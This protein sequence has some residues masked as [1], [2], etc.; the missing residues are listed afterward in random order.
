MQVHTVVDSTL[1]DNTIAGATGRLVLVVVGEGDDWMA[2]RGY[3]TSMGWDVERVDLSVMADG[4]AVD[5]LLPP[6]E[7]LDAAVVV[8]S[9]AE[10]RPALGGERHLAQVAR[11]VGMLQGHL[12]PSRVLVLAE[13]D[14]AGEVAGAGVG[15][16]VYLSGQVETQFPRLR[17]MLGEAGQR[18]SSG[19]PFGTT[20]LG[21]AIASLAPELWLVLGPL[22]VLGAFLAVLGLGLLNWRAT[23]SPSAP[24]PASPEPGISTT[25]AA[26]TD[27][28]REQEGTGPD[29]LQLLPVSCTIDTRLGT[30]LAP[31]ID[32]AGAGIVTVDGFSGPWHNELSTVALDSAVVGA[33]ILEPVGG[34]SAP[35]RVQ[36]R[37]GAETSLGSSAGAGVG[38]V[39]LV[40][41]ADGQRAIFSGPSA[42]QQAVLTFRLGGR[43]A[44]S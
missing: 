11:L 26:S 30:T 4:S 3:V 29:G 10:G 15:E 2:V 31:T 25:V 37:A 18:E 17:A 43:A 22:L 40:F 42:G 34:S 1:S 35:D 6:F 16:A 9:S 33:V 23:T 39:E 41:G 28:A 8:L 24:A 13:H 36:L 20:R 32:C 27:S 14:L 21:S 12:G 7:G 44:G 5:E 38:R 19:P